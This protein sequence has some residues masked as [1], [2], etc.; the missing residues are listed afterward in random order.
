MLSEL[1]RLSS[2]F[3]VQK[4]HSNMKNTLQKK[5]ALILMFPAWGFSQINGAYF[6]ASSSGNIDTVVGG[7]SN[8]STQVAFN[9][10]ALSR[11]GGWSSVPSGTTVAANTSVTAGG[12][13]P[14]QHVQ[15]P[16]SY[17]LKNASAR[18][19]ITGGAYNVRGFTTQFFINSNVVV[20]ILGPTLN[21]FGL[22]GA[23]NFTWSITGTGFTSSGSGEAN[24]SVPASAGIV[25]VVVSPNYYYE[26]GWAMVQAAY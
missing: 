19:I 1:F 14:I 9:P 10:T 6:N 11:P 26:Y 20:S 16:G 18:S 12:S 3:P 15:T 4:T 21:S 8:I 25:S 5:I 22:T 23:T 13:Y 24:V 7:V 2:V 17:S